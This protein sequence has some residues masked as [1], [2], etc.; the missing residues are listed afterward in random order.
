MDEKFPI[1]VIPKLLR[2]VILRTL[3][4]GHR[5]RKSILATGANIWRPRL[6]REVVGI[7]QTCQQCKTAG[8]NIEPLLRQKQKKKKLPECKEINRKK[9]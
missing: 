7:A 1:K 4:Y 8:K 6:H 2:P 5:K 9:T 3:H